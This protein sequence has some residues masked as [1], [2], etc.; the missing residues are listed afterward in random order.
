[1]TIKLELVASFD[2]YVTSINE[3]FTEV[4]EALDNEEWDKASD[5]MTAISTAQ[6]RVSIQ[7]RSAIVR[8]TS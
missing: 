3:W 1:M 6:A 8:L 7:I 4:R 2:D 5:L